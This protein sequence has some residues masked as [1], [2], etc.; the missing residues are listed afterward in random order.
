M[1]SVK[2]LHCGDAHIG[3]M[4][5]FLGENAAKRRFETLL[6]FEKTVNTAR[7][8]NEN[9]RTPDLRPMQWPGNLPVTSSLLLSSRHSAT[10]CNLSYSR[11]DVFL[12]LRMDILSVSALQVPQL[13]LYIHQR[14]QATG[15]FR[16]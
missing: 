2:I 14:E 13:S 11:R 16:R 12:S 4:G 6:T 5:S 10:Y 9:A 1:A 8:H 7:E 15:P 3:A